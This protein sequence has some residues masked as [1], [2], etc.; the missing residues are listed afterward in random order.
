MSFL[1]AIAIAISYL[2]SNSTEG[3]I[4]EK[5]IW[6]ISTENV[7]KQNTLQAA[8]GELLDL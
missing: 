3:V 1:F 4:C 7:S 2:N 8:P 6:S 5:F